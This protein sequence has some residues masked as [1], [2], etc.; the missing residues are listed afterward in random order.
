VGT[1]ISKR[2]LGDAPGWLEVRTTALEEVF[3]FLVRRGFE[4]N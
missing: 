4:L 2:S 3:F 1:S